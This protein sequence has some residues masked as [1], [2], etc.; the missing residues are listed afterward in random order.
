MTD[1][2]NYNESMEYIKS[3]MVR[4]ETIRNAEALA[5]RMGFEFVRTLTEA[6]LFRMAQKDPDVVPKDQ[7]NSF[8]Q[9]DLVIESTL[10]GE[11]QYVAAE[12]SFTG[13]AGDAERAIRNCQ[14]PHP[15]NRL[16]GNSGR[17]QRQEEPRA[18][19]P[20]RV[21]KSSLAPH[22][23]LGPGTGITGQVQIFPTP[24]SNGQPRNSPAIPTPQLPEIKN[25]TPSVPCLK[26][27]RDQ[28]E[29]LGKGHKP[30]HK[31]GEAA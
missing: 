12:I 1:V 26:L 23:E 6:D 25:Q 28:K 24:I 30:S 8:K 19:L 14:F 2:N 20:H 29:S 13:T 21:W 22:H 15:V 27:S 16:P 17:G 7:L 10:D 9:A 18:R 11:T 5:M 4:D 3:C 31:A